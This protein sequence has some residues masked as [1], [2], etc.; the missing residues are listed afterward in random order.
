MCVC[1]HPQYTH[2]WI[3]QHNHQFPLSLRTTK[4]IFL[5]GAADKEK[6]KCEGDNMLNFSPE[7]SSIL[8]CRDGLIFLAQIIIKQTIIF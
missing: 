1:I 8:Q 2:I 3:L 6:K 7:F 4:E 5:K